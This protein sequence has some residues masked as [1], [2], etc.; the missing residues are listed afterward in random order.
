METKARRPSQRDQQLD[1]VRTRR[2]EEG[3]TVPDLGTRPASHG[4]VIELARSDQRAANEELH[5]WM[6]GWREEDAA[7]RSPKTYKNHGEDQIRKP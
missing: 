5:E 3:L 1:L 7:V 6:H 2:R 4:A